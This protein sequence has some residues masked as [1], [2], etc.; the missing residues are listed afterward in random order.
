MMQ[1]SSEHIFGVAEAQGG[2]PAASGAAASGGEEQG[3][4]GWGYSRLCRQIKDLRAWCVR[5][6]ECLQHLA[7]FMACAWFGIAFT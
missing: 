1:A 6:R 7:R 5:H 2:K 4:F 3:C